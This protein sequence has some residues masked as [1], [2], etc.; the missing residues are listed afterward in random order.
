MQRHQLSRVDFV[1]MDIEGAEVVALEGATHTLEA[2]RP[3]ILVECHGSYERMTEQLSRLGY[4]WDVID[5]A[6]GREHILCTA[7]L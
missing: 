4:V 3:A 5:G 7:S 1:K 6:S 2:Y